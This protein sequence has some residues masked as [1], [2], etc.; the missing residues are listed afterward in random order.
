MLHGG[1][2]AQRQQ[3][4]DIRPTCLVRQISAL[5]QVS[6][7]MLGQASICISAGQTASPVLVSQSAC[8]SSI[9]V[10]CRRLQ[11][12]RCSAC[13]ASHSFSR[14]AHAVCPHNVKLSLLGPAPRP[15]MQSHNAAWHGTW[16]WQ[17]THSGRQ[18]FPYTNTPLT[19]T[20]KC[21]PQSAHQLNYRLV[22]KC[23]IGG[24]V[25]QRMLHSAALS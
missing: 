9:P 3:K 11:A 16:T 13:L 7:P 18:V 22:V 24:P 19:H 5:R 15:A 25:Q 6:V 2:Q 20:F 23:C 21:Q 10:W 8:L 4:P 1:R 12:Y 17:C 14:A